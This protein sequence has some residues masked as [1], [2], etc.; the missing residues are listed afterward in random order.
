MGQLDY[1]RSDNIGQWTT[2]DED[3]AKLIHAAVTCGM[4]WREEGKA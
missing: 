4:G 3:A 2:V 1:S